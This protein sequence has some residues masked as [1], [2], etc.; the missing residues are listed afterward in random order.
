MYFGILSENQ[1]EVDGMVDDP[2]DYDIK[3]N[4]LQE[5]IKRICDKI[6]GLIDEDEIERE[7]MINEAINDLSGESG[8]TIM[9]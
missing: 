5:S 7:K 1:K 6:D 8:T 9:D 3:N 2:V 4:T